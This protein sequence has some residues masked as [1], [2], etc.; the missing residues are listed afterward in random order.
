M[1]AID[2]LT[3]NHVA[4]GIRYNSHFRIEDRLGDIVD[5]VLAAPRHGSSRFPLIAYGAGM[6]QLGN[7]QTGESISFSRADTIFENRKANFLLAQLPVM[8]EEFAE[9]VWRAVYDHAKA[10]AVTRFGCIVGFDLPSTWRPL[11]ALLDQ[12]ERDTSEFDLR[13]S[14]RLPVEDALTNVG[15]NDYR[16]VIFQVSCRAERK[17]ATI[18]FQHYFNPP[19]ESEKARKET[20]YSKFINKAIPYFR[21]GGWDFLRSR[22]ER[23][24]R[25]A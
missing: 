9:D 23:L 15:V 25:A 17:I 6:R 8:A 12:D 5:A 19:L 3:L 18:D 20:S 1:A 24:P 22:L 4:F 21:D 11:D 13:Y 10:P 2:D 14:H 7:E 16:N